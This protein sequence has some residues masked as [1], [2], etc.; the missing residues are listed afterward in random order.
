[1]ASKPPYL[2][3]KG[4][5]KK[6]GDNTA[7]NHIDLDI[8]QHEIFALL[9]SSGSGQP[10]IGLVGLGQRQL[11]LH[12]HE[13]V[14]V[15][16]SSGRQ[17]VFGQFTGRDVTALQGGADGAEVAGF[18]PGLGCVCFYYLRIASMLWRC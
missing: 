12:V 14:D 1:M 10:G 7:V 15:A 3:I 5:V 6:F 16:G 18:Q 17:T 2:Q 4:L 11:G 9:G 8:Q 13:G